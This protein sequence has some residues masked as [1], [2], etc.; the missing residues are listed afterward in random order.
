MLLAICFNKL[1]D[2]QQ[3]EKYITLQI[4]SEE[5]IEGLFYYGKILLKREKYQ[6]AIH[7]FKMILDKDP[8]HLKAK[9]LL[10]EIYQKTNDFDKCIEQGGKFIEEIAELIKIKED[11]QF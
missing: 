3:A 5:N 4:N 10:T 6:E 7:K 1:K 11:T 9:L 2:L 8:D